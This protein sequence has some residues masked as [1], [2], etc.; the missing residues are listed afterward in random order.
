MPEEPV[1]RKKKASTGFFGIT[2]D[3]AQKRRL[4]PGFREI[5]EKPAF[6][7]YERIVSL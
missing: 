1:G 5:S 4:M 2:T 6:I 7:P 3:E